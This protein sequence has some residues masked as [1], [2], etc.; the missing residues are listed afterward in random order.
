[1]N[2]AQK[3]IQAYR[4]TPW[5]RQIN[6]IGTFVAFGLVATLVMLAYVW[7]TSKAGAYGLQVQEIQETNQYLE[8]EIEN[9]KAELGDITRNEA[10]AERA[11]EIGFVPAESDQLRYLVVPGYP[12]EP[13]PAVIPQAT[14]HVA[15]QGNTLPPEYTAS[16]LDWLQAFIYDL[17]V[18]SGSAE[19][20]GN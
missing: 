18:M 20:G 16:L 9:A 12:G 14:P 6:M 11:T 19:I 8:Q 15:G 5:R 13:T 1:M 4:N 2:R 3:I 17:S 10:M 7:V